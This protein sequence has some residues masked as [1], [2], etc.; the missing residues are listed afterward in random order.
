QEKDM[1]LNK[2]SGLEIANTKRLGKTEETF[3]QELTRLPCVLN[4]SSST[5]I[6]TKN[7]FGDGYSPEPTQ[8]DI[9]LI[10]DIGLSSFMVDE[11]FIPTLKI[12]ILQ[13]RNFSKAFND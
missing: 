4:P 7:F 12:Q 11:H 8:T 9:P 2:E 10:N 13:G 5:G 1:G 3:R 6:P